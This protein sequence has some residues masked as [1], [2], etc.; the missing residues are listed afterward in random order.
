MWC[1]SWLPGGAVCSPCGKPIPPAPGRSTRTGREPRS[2][3]AKLPPTG[4]RVSRSPQQRHA[5]L[6]LGSPS[7]RARYPDN[8]CER[9]PDQ[10]PAQSTPQG[11]K[12]RASR[13]TLRWRMSGGYA[14]G[15]R[16][17]ESEKRAGPGDDGQ[18]IT[19]RLPP[20]GHRDARPSPKQGFASTRRTQATPSRKSRSERLTPITRDAAKPGRR[21]SRTHERRFAQPHPRL[22]PSPVEIPLLE[23]Y[24]AETA[25]SRSRIA[26]HL[27]PHFRLWSRTERGAPAGPLR[28]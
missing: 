13:S 6:T 26:V 7:S 1:G 9:P 10:T 22:A 16:A 5:A 21:P 24:D 25:G 23:P 12:I 19:R 3:P 18:G 8:S 4:Q 11:A 17:S 15:K 2:T 20:C 14:R 28:A 27:R